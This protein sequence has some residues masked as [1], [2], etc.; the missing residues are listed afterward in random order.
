MAPHAN[1]DGLPP[2]TPGG[3]HFA[4]DYGTGF[5]SRHFEI[6]DGGNISR[7]RRADANGGSAAKPNILYIMADQMAA[8][9]L[10][11]HNPNSL[12]KTPNIDRLAEAGV[13]FDNAYCGSPLCA[14]SRFCMVSGQLA[15]KIG[16]Y[17]NAA[18]LSSDIPTYAHYLRREG[19]ETVLAGKMHF[20]GP[21]QLHGYEHRLTPDIYP[22]DL[23]WSVNWDAPKVR[24]EWYH[25]MS[26]VLQ[27]GP[28]VRSN[29][30]D[31]DEEVVYKSTQW[32][33]DYVRHDPSG[34]RP[35]CLTVSLTHPHDPYTINEEQWDKYEDVDI[36]LPDVTIPE[37]E[38]DPHTLRILKAIDSYGRPLPEEAIKRARRAYY[39]AC[40]YVDDQVGKLL[41]VLKDT[42]LADNTIIVFSGDHGDMLGERSMW[43]KMSWYEMSARVPLI[44]H[45][46]RKF[47]AHRVPE[48]VSTMDLLPTFVDLVGGQLDRRIHLDGRSFYGA[49]TGTSAPVDEVFGEYMGESTI[50]PLM[51]IR[52][53]RYKYVVCLADPPQ[54]FDLVSDPKELTN[55]AAS[56]DPKISAVSRAFAAQAGAKWDLEKIH[57]DVLE[58]Q[59]RRRL[60]W[61]ALQKGRFEAW[62]YEPPAEAKNKYIRSTIPLDDLE[63][64]ARYPPVDAFGREGVF[65]STHGLAAARGQ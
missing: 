36:P 55:I 53:G 39:G 6:R 38:Q 2:T 10:K 32:L 3:S 20:I 45:Y 7:E 64:R 9:A 57:N 63:R 11:L 48:S 21:D 51:M 56:S 65:A 43:Y 61:G 35:F 19:Y 47:A 60:V 37:S 30:L 18:T 4:V 54:L 58:S 62:D 34:Q 24:Q 44:V 31:F 25:N 49:L 33:H 28:C 5:P 26:S 52:R 46:P 40:S 42:R 17:D 16:A 12:I 27:A 59:R 22:G 1:G 41:K 8:P 14:P 50:S 29:Q 13:V 23:G 15:S